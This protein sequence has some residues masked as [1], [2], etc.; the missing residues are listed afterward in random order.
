M[1]Y[2]KMQGT[3]LNV[4]ETPKGVNRDGEEYGGY[5]QVQLLCDEPLKNGEIRKQ[6]FTFRCDEPET[7]KG[8]LGKPVS[9]P[10]GVFVKAGSMHF[11]MARQ[12]VARKPSEV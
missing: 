2:L 11:Y 9:V 12:L 4:L 1:S 10:V 5:H 6:M 8:R 7:F 3:V